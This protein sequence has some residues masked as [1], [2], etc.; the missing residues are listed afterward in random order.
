MERMDCL[1]MFNQAEIWE[2]VLVYLFLEPNQ[3]QNG[4][5][6][7]KMQPTNPNAHTYY[8]IGTDVQ[9]NGFAITQHTFLQ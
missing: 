7:T 2:I 4:T 6:K 8:V 3:T 9:T 1:E 5:R